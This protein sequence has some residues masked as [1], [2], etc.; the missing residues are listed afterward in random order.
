MSIRESLDEIVGGINDRIKTGSLNAQ[1]K[2]L[3]AEKKKLFAQ[4]DQI[5][6]EV[7]TINEKI[8]TETERFH[9]ENRYALKEA[10]AFVQS[11]DFPPAKYDVK[12]AVDALLRL[13]FREQ[14]RKFL[15]D[16]LT[17]LSNQRDP[18]DARLREI[19]NELAVIKG[20]L[21]NG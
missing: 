9:N 1:H 15:G 16:Q 8:A 13:A 10:P 6:G 21:L 7:N 11:E 14:R 2:S 17:E 5:T 12:Q 18:I 4:R 19:D 3:V 20:K